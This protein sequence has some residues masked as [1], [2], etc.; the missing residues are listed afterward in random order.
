[1]PFFAVNHLGNLIQIPAR[2]FFAKDME[3][4]IEPCHG[5]LGGDVIRKTDKE[6]VEILLQEGL[7]IRVVPESVWKGPISPECPVADGDR[8]KE[9]MLIDALPT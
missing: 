5:N 6:D 8:S 2:W 1:M 9:R 4:P 3:I 7:V